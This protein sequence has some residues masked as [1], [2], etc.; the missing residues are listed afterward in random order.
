MAS[1]SLEQMDHFLRHVK[2][3]ATEL[4]NGTFTKDLG[5]YLSKLKAAQHLALEISHDMIHVMRI[6]QF[7]GYED[8]DFSFDVSLPT[9]LD[10][11]VFRDFDYSSFKVGCKLKNTLDLGMVEDKNILLSKEDAEEQITTLSN[12]IQDAGVLIKLLEHFESS[13]W[14]ATF[15]DEGGL[16]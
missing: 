8:A 9:E 5:H 11:H 15:H 3:H 16:F 1:M 14:K 2:V 12:A 6:K 7:K 13:K 4:K 10:S